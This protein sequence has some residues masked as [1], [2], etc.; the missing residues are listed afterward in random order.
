M[1]DYKIIASP[2]MS[3][4]HDKMVDEILRLDTLSDFLE[5][6]EPGNLLNITA[7]NL[8]LLPHRKP[9]F[10]YAFTTYADGKKVSIDS[11]SK[12]PTLTLIY[13]GNNQIKYSERLYHLN[14]TKS[15]KETIYYKKLI[16][17][18]SYLNCSN[19]EKSKHIVTPNKYPHWKP[20]ETICSIDMLFKF[21]YGVH[22]IH[23]KTICYSTVSSVDPVV[24]SNGENFF[25][26]S[27]YFKKL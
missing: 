25:S 8:A 1:K 15:I 3:A 16:D 5:K 22:E 17:Q 6:I 11:L 24:E 7:E 23:V 12:N 27:W 20:K 26:D 21:I 14:K 13:L 4:Y 10:F 9:N 18:P 2:T 19:P